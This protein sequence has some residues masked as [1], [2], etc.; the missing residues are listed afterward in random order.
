MLSPKCY[1]LSKY[2]SFSMLGIAIAFWFSSTS[3]AIAKDSIH[4]KRREEFTFITHT[5]EAVYSY[6]EIKQKRYHFSYAALK[7][8]TAHRVEAVRSDAAYHVVLKKFIARFHDGHLRL[9]FST[10][11]SPPVKRPAAVTHRSVGSGIL[12][13]HIARLTGNQSL[14]R[15]ELSRGLTLL[16]RARGLIVDLR[17]NPG[18]NNQT[19]FDYVAKLFSKPILL[20]HS[21]VRLSKLVLAQ[22]PH[23][24]Q[25]Y[26]PDPKRPGFSIWREAILEPQT[27]SG[28]QGPIA[29]LI[30]QGCYSSCESTALAFKQSGRATLYGQSTGGGSGNPITI[31]LPY[32]RGKLMVP[33]WMFRMPDGKLLEDRG[34]SPQVVLKRSSDALA[35]AIKQMKSAIRA[36]QNSK[37]RRP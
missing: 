5:L 19:S 2:G 14:I 17:S 37:A 33:T 36:T 28:F 10:G 20:G 4:A 22:R 32:S 34:V 31:D 3:S 29:V 1:M 23:Y 21:S 15:R 6:L 26:P 18:G 30:N 24:R 7:A 16:R 12:L 25:L 8:K 27:T 13:T 9:I 11:P 35:V